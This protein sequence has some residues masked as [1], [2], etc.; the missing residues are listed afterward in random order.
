MGAEDFSRSQKD[1]RA[2]T[3]SFLGQPIQVKKSLRTPYFVLDKDNQCSAEDLLFG[4]HLTGRKDTYNSSTYP[5][6]GAAG[7]T[8]L[9]QLGQ[10]VVIACNHKDNTEAVQGVS[11]ET[12]Y[13]VDEELTK[14]VFRDRTYTVEKSLKIPFALKR[15]KTNPQVVLLGFLLVGYIGSGGY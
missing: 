11:W 7:S 12:A 5:D 15:P 9:E 1:F 14:W 4:L 13:E 8:G 2:A 10:L 6:W 3:W